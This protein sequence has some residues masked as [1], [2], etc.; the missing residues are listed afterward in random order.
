MNDTIEPPEFSLNF[1]TQL[2]QSYIH[3]HTAL[4]AKVCRDRDI[5]HVQLI[6]TNR[7]KSRYQPMAW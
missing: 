1:V 3:A 2:N 5:P 6:M 4:H 7:L